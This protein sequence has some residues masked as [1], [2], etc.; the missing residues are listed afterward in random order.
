MD[1]FV[2]VGFYVIWLEFVDVLLI[3]ELFVVVEC[4]LKDYNFEICILCGEIVNVSVDECVL[5]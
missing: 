2:C 4:K 5:D 1:K 3:D